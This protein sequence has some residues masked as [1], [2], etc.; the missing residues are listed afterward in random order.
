MRHLSVPDH[1]PGVQIRLIH[2]HDLGDSKFLA[3]MDR[4]IAEFMQRDGS[5]RYGVV[6]FEPERLESLYD[7]DGF[8]RY[9]ADGLYPLVVD[10][11]KEVLF[12]GQPE[13]F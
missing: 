2:D 11:V 12:D 3:P 10:A 5:I 7:P 1:I 4:V 9:V 13:A 6:R 8:A